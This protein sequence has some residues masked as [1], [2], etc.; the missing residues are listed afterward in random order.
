MA[1]TT[2]TKIAAA[3]RELTEIEAEL[4]DVHGEPVAEYPSLT[5]FGDSKGHE[6]Q[7]IA[8]EI[9]GVDRGEISE[10]MHDQASD[11]DYDWSHADPVVVLR[12]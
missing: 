8:N 2:D 5:V 11:V 10:W 12:D 7:E 4:R 9:D 6:L 1:E 3:S